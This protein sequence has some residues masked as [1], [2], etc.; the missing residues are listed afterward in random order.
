M[1]PLGQIWKFPIK[2]IIGSNT[3]EVKVPKGT[4]ILSFGEDPEKPEYVVW[5]KVPDIYEKK[6]EGLRVFLI[7][8]GQ[9]IPAPAES[10]RFVNTAITPSA[11]GP[12]EIHCFVKNN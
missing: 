7:P 11:F 2:D 8:T 5:G 9:S 4:E 6:E 12:F 1:G 10:A 3:Y